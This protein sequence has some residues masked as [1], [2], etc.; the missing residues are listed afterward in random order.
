[1]AFTYEER[2]Q[3][4]VATGIGPT[5]VQRL[6]EAGVDSLDK[7]RQVGVDR[8]VDRICSRIGSM[9]WATRRRALARVLAGPLQAR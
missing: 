2:R 3:L 6:E 4:L 7:L 9:G 8:A 5:V 1:M